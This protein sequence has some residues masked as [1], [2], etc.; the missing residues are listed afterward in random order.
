[1]LV[2]FDRGLA[3]KVEDLVKA[4]C[5]RAERPSSGLYSL[6]RT[7]LMEEAAPKDVFLLS[8]E[9]CSAF[10]AFMPQFYERFIKSSDEIRQK[11]KGTNLHIQKQMLLRSL[12]LSA[13]ATAGDR[14]ALQEINDRSETHDRAHLDIRPGLYEYWLDAIIQTAEQFDPDW[15]QTVEAAWRR[16]LGHVVKHI[17]R[18]Y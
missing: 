12:K 9:R 13:G 7:A 18:N 16:I 5:E 14:D 15:D 10:D 6:F 1:M 4:C 17:S 3:V 8:L 2:C 11:F